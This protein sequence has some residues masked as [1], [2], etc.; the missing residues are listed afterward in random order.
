MHNFKDIK[1]VHLEVTTKCNANC[2]MCGRNYHGITRSGLELNEMTLGDFKKIF[3]LPFLK[4]LKFIS[5][6]GVYG[7][8]ILAK[9]LIKIIEYIYKHV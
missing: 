4:Q 3:S 1:S 9:D 6:C 2:A 5:M 8:S 7:D